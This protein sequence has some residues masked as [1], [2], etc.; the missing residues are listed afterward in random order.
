MV[1]AWLLLRTTAIE[2]GDRNTAT[3]ILADRT[4]TVNDG[5]RRQV[6][7]TVVQLRNH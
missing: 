1:R 2:R 3:Y 4:I 7:S 6:F 5:F